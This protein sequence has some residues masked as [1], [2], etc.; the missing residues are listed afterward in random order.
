MDANKEEFDKIS[1][2]IELPLSGGGMWKWSLL[3]PSQLLVS[4]VSNSPAL[5]Q[6]YADAWRRSP[7]SPQRPWSLVVTFDEF[8]PG[9]KLQTD[10]TRKTMV[11]SFSFLQLGQAALSFG[12]CWTTAICVRSNKIKEA[13]VVQARRAFV[14]PTSCSGRLRR[15]IALLALHPSTPQRLIRLRLRYSSNQFYSAL[16]LP[17]STIHRRRFQLRVSCTQQACIDQ[18]DGGW[19]SMLRIV[20]DMLL[21]GPCGLQV[22]GIPLPIGGQHQLL[23]A[24]L[25]N[26]LSD[27]DGLRMALDWKGA[28]GLKPCFKHW[29]VFKLRSGLAHRKRGFVEIDCSNLAS[30][31]S[32]TSEHLYKVFDSVAVARA[33]CLAGT[34][35][36]VMY[37]DLAMSTGLNA[38]PRGLLSQSPLRK[39]V[40]A[41]LQRVLDGVSQS[42]AWGG[43]RP[44]EAWNVIVD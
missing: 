21:L 23:F 11:L 15:V 32:W 28:S 10:Q 18:V 35:T 7:P 19:S 8:V 36:K 1:R 16:A 13:S 22:A 44:R 42:F 9:N 3:D 26:L 29:N 5:Q 40:R 20:L 14:T 25:T 2:T 41:L 12:S 6:L 30:F 4:L 39:S 34:M 24:R 37:E 31:R 27:G 17:T 43:A 38:N 33:A